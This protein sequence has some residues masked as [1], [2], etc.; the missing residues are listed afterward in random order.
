MSISPIEMVTYERE[1]TRR[2]REATVLQA[3]V[4]TVLDQISGIMHEMM[5]D[6]LYFTFAEKLLNELNT[7]LGVLQDAVDRNEEDIA[8]LTYCMKEGV[9]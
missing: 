2:V 9:S 6:P 4:D 5:N 7:T 3:Q 8:F 1:R